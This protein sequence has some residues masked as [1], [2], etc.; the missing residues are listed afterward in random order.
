MNYWNQARAAL[1]TCLSFSQKPL[2][3]LVW[4]AALVPFARSIAIGACSNEIKYGQPDY[5]DW[6]KKYT[7]Y[8]PRILFFQI[9]SGFGALDAVATAHGQGPD[10][11]SCD[12]PEGNYVADGIISPKTKSVGCAFYSRCK[13]NFLDGYYQNLFTQVIC[14]FDRAW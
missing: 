2:T 4:N 1:A 9:G 7:K 13:A 5:L 8:W 11:F 6:S 3:P 10:N 14:V 12:G